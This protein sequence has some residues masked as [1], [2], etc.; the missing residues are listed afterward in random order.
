MSEPRIRVQ[1]LNV[2]YGARSALENI[3]A[4]IPAKGITA[5][6]GPSGCGKTTLLRSL[7]R[8]IEE[9]DGVR[10]TG[11]VLLESTPGQGSRFTLELSL[12]P[13]ASRQS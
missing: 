8:L 10:L 7:N 12:T 11:Q 13:L 4:D 6:V 9:T 3:T 1:N 5:I 2:W